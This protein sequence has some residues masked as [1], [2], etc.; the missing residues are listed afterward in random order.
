MDADPI[1]PS[2]R[3]P[4]SRPP[5]LRVVMP[6]AVALASLLAVVAVL[7]GVESN[8]REIR[9]EINS[10]VE[11]GRTQLY[12]LQRILALEDAAHRGYLLTRSEGFLSEHR[13]LVAKEDSAFREL[14]PL[15]LELGPETAERFASFRELADRWR[16]TAFARE[17]VDAAP[18]SPAVME[19]LVEQQRLYAE[20]LAAAAALE[21]A[22]QR[23]SDERRDRIERLERA[24]IQLV[25]LLVVV[26]LGS[27]LAIVRAARQMRALAAR[28]Q[29]LALEAQERQR[30]LERV[31]E[32]KAQFIRGVTH[33]LKN[34]L[35]AVDAFAQLMESGLRG[36]LTE[37]QLEWVRRIRRATQE[38]LSTIHDLLE[39]ARAD[40]GWLRVERRSADV[41]QTAADAA[42]DYRAAL[43]ASGHTLRVDPP[44]FLPSIRTD[45]GRVREI[46]ANLL[47]NANKYTPAGGT[48][49]VGA[50]ARRRGAPGEGEWVSLWVR[51]TG[52]GI[53]PGEQERIFEEFHRVGGTTAPGSGV[54]LSIAR[55]VARLLG[56]EL[57]VESRPGE[58][59]CFVLWLPAQ[60]PAPADT[61]QGVL[62]R[63]L[64][65]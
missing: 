38:A 36:E 58:G 64:H 46:L 60:A 8:R 28:A 21:G 20:A 62:E 59:A 30:E 61:G 50:E 16:E 54:G 47:N 49:T 32:E 43:E 13:A 53:P 22:I 25:L 23:A 35:G 42:E 29:R 17:L 10:A 12:D 34:P 19:E 7:I 6:V 26:A 56:G 45:P 40:G 65:G 27:V 39:L 52:P 4:A 48:I 63:S 57:T 51:D 9:L 15:A 3:A 5:G 31:A 2:G 37:G 11:P 18:R 33:D 24:E 41:W 44:E 55:R 1:H 14:R